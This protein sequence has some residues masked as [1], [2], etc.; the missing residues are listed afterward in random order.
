MAPELVDQSTDFSCWSEEVL[1][2]VRSHQDGE[3]R[4]HL[5]DLRQLALLMLAV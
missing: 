5:S 3:I 1:K 2:P 4:N